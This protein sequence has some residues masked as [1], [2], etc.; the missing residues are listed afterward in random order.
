MTSPAN[1]PDPITDI[2]RLVDIS[3]YDLEAVQMREALHGYAQ[4]A[5]AALGLPV[6]LVTIVL[7]GAQYTAGSYGIDGTWIGDAGG[8]PVEWSFCRNV[9]RTGAPY[10]IE[11]ASTHALEYDNPLVVEDGAR[12]YAG[13]P[14]VSPAGNVLGACCVIGFEPHQFSNDD[15]EQLAMLADEAVTELNRF[16]VA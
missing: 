14:L 2:D 13:A 7:D 15:L 12:S 16:R 11:D 3:T 1:T 8:T 6:G 4:R 9:V 5:A 10:I